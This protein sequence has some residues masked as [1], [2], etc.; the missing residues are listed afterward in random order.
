MRL[1]GPPGIHAV[2]LRGVLCGIF[3]GMALLCVAP[4]A[5]ADEA[6]YDVEID[7]P[8]NVKSLIEDNISL[9][10]WRDADGRKGRIDED[11]LRRLFDQGKDEIVR[12]I[13]TEGY[14]APVV[15]ADLEQ[16]G[17]RWTAHYRITPNALTTV[18]S[19]DIQFQGPIA[20]APA[21]EKPE[22]E[23]LRQNWTLAAGDVFRQSD[24]ETNKRR[25]LQGLLI[26]T[27]PFASITRSEAQVDIRTSKAKLSVVVASGPAV[28]FGPLQVTGLKRYPEDI[29]R[30]LDPIDLGELYSQAQVFEFQRRLSSSG[31]FS[32]VEVSIDAVADPGSDP[33]SPFVAPEKKDGEG[34]AATA[35]APATPLPR[36]VTLPL[37]VLVEE[38]K[39]KAVSLG[40]GLSTNSGPRASAEYDI[41][42]FLGGGKQ[43]RTKLSF[44]RLTQSLGADLIFPTTELGNRYS[45]SSYLR[46]ENV[47]NEVTRSAGVTGKRAWGPADTERFT[48]LDYIYEQKDV[49]YVPQIATQILGTTYGVTLR[50]TDSL[51]TPTSGYLASGTVGAGLRLM[52]G[53]PYARAYGKAVRYQPLGPNDTL[54]VRIELGAIAG[55]DTETLP[56]TLLFRAGGQGSVRGYGYQSLGIRQAD[57]IVGGRYVATGTLEGIHWL[58]PKYPNWGVAAFIDAGNAGNRFSDLAPVY[59]YG[60]GA[61]WR[62]PVGVLDLDVAHGIQNGSTRLHFS[63]GVTF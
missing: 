50:R 7:A 19:V 57:A 34:T 4:Q 54:L 6:R 10:R 26:R 32:R 11:Q 12:L 15:D 18:E 59:G 25:L 52:T 16:K 44:D 5:R 24:W 35:D 1:T 22:R 41:I 63:L 45:I 58:G 23:A 8:G 30:N 31:Y 33:R 21:G 36:E 47:Q 46:R 42:N 61:R 48:T 39:S 43:L 51:L 38:N 9:I 62:S 60:V 55:A 27:Y 20:Q 40:V 49:S 13:A 2:R 28:R 3:V 17:D 29:V 14:Y 37:R 56:S 53:Q